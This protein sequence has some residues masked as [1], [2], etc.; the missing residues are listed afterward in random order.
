MRMNLPSISARHTRKTPGWRTNNGAKKQ[1]MPEALMDVGPPVFA[2]TLPLII[3]YSMRRGTFHNIQTTVSCATARA[4]GAMPMPSSTPLGILPII[5]RA[6]NP[7]Y[8][9]L[10]YGAAEQRKL[11]PTIDPVD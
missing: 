2:H 8:H 5:L 7:L 6:M 9:Y 11:P 3:P 1:R 10:R 4:K